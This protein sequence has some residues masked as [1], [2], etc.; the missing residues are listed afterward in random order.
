MIRICQQCGIEFKCIPALV[1]RGGGM[2]CSIW[3]R[4]KAQRTKVSCQ[5]QSCG[6]TFSKKPCDIKRGGGKYCSIE[7]YRKKPSVLLDREC[8]ICGTGFRAAPSVIVDG[9]GK[10]CSIKC[11]GM[12]RRG[13]NHHNWKGGIT[14]QNHLWRTSPE[15]EKWR[16]EVL[17][18]DNYTCQD[19]GDRSYKG[20]GQRVVLHIHHIFNFA[21]F[22]EHRYE[23]WNGTTLCRKCHA[24]IHP[25]M[26]TQMF[27]QG[28]RK[29]YA[30]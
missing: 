7:C 12:A 1:A 25:A 9:G 18:R 22:P 8:P 2:Y 11:R 10:H 15:Y 21:D 23:I 6:K 16:K 17:A 14:P 3:C 5:C 19:C 24:K 20:R 27:E 30:E 29:S 4:G 28:V 13:E 26:A